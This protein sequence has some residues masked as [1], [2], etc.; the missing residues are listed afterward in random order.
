[1]IIVNHA[2]DE[3]ACPEPRGLSLFLHAKRVPLF[4]APSV[5]FLSAL[6]VKAFSD[7]PG[8]APKLLYASKLS[9]ARTMRPNQKGRFLRY[10]WFVGRPDRCRYMRHSYDAIHW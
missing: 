7:P 1:M 6:C 9:A 2:S 10:A 3:D 5:R 8:R 4:S